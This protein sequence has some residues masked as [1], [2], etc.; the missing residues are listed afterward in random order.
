MRIG[1]RSLILAYEFGHVSSPPG[2]ARERAVREGKGKVA[3][4]TRRLSAATR[5]SWNEFGPSSVLKR[6]SLR[7]MVE[8]SM[9]LAGI[10]Q[11]TPDAS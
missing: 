10:E 7:Q 8:A 6:G 9:G 11:E 2:A 4:A 3:V 5:D 1:Y